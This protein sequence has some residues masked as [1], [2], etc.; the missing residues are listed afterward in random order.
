MTQH[1]QLPARSIRSSPTYAVGLG[2]QPAD[3]RWL[4]WGRWLF[5]D[6]DKRPLAPGF[7]ITSAEAEA[8]GLV[9]ATVTKALVEETAAAPSVL[10]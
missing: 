3:P 5:A 4:A 10:Q 7:E 1:S 2:L 8:R 9:T 6:G